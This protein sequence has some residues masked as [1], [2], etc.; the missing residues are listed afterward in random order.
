MV[1]LLGHHPERGKSVCC[2]HSKQDHVIKVEAGRVVAV[3]EEYQG[4][5]STGTHPEIG[6]GAYCILFNGF[7]TEFN[8][9]A[10]Y[11]EIFDF[12]DVDLWK[13]KLKYKGVYIFTTIELALKAVSL[14]SNLKLAADC[15]EDGSVPLD[16]NSVHFQ[17]CSQV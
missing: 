6:K 10:K 15:A 4:K 9:N 14:D 1:K 11:F 16:N 12:D 17:V 7:Y 2:A 8:N 13:R 3:M 5:Y